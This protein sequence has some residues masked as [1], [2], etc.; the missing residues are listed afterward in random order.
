MRFLI[1]GALLSVPLF[2]SAQQSQTA[3]VVIPSMAKPSEL[4]FQ[5]GECDR[6]GDVMACTF[7]QVFLRQAAG[8]DACQIITNRYELRFTR[9]SAT[10]W[11]SNQG[12]SGDCGIVDVTTLDEEPR[13]PASFWTM[14]SRKTIPNRNAGAACRALVDAEQPETLTWRD[15]KRALSCRFIVPGLIQ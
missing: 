2:V 9:Q 5:G 13:G 4:D 3:H 12:P 10:R 11:V 7:Q 6:T 1:A 14:T 8:D 15:T